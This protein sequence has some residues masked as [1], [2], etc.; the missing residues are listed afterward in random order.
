MDLRN[1]QITI[2][3]LLADP[4]AKEVLERQEA[5]TELKAL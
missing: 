5:L 3:E 2:R 4:R 1:H